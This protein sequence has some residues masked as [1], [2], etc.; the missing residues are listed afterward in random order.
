MPSQSLTVHTGFSSQHSVVFISHTRAAHLFTFVLRN[1]SPLQSDGGPNPATG[2]SEQTALSL[3]HS[4]S[5]HVP[6]AHW[7][8]LELRYVPAGQSL[9]TQTGFDWQH[10][11][12]V[13]VMAAQLSVNELR[14][15][16]AEHR[17]A[18]HFSCG[19]QQS[20]AT[21]TPAAHAAVDSLPVDP[22]AQVAAAAEAPAEV[23]APQLSGPRLVVP[24]FETV[25]PIP[26]ISDTT[27][28]APA[29]VQ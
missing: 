18:L 1:Q 20:A 16:V 9:A 26:A 24:R 10:S 14:C 17:A 8:V 21:H 15:W 12:C 6:D 3:Q 27:K 13:Q 22:A 25:H 5:V 11:V 19:V 2:P 4:S 28:P 29:C 7:L 23:G